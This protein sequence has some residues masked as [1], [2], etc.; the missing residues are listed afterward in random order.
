MELLGTLYLEE[1]K[2][3]TISLPMILRS[4]WSWDAT[5]IHQLPGN[6][7]T[8]TTSLIQLLLTYKSPQILIFSIIRTVISTILFIQEM[9]LRKLTDSL[10]IHDFS[11]AGEWND[12]KKSLLEFIWAAHWGVKGVVRR[13]I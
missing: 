10:I 5:S 8:T 13:I 3:S 9:I 4:L 7:T 6:I 12:N 1:C 2:T 11:L